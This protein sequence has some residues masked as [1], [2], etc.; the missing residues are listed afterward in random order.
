MVFCPHT[1]SYADLRK[2]Q[3]NRLKSQLKTPTPCYIINPPSQKLAIADI[4]YTDGRQLTV[5]LISVALMKHPDKRTL[6]EKGVI[7]SYN[8][9]LYSPL[10]WRNQG[11]NFQQCCDV[12]VW[13]QGL[14]WVNREM[15]KGQTHRKAGVRWTGS[16]GRNQS[17]PEAQRVYY[18]EL[19]SEAR[20]LHPAK[21]GDVVIMYR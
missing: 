11:R 6:E 19:N 8:F 20:L 5:A 3:S 17:H 7:L 1:S 15:K 2:A 18:I 4:C 14:A 9:R 13:P 12:L 21:Q 10:L 16:L